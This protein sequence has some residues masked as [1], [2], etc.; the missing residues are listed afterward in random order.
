MIKKLLALWH[1]YRETEKQNEEIKKIDI[2]VNGLMKI[3]FNEKSTF[4]SIQIKEKFLKKFNQEIIKRNL[5]AQIE[6]ADCE[7]YLNKIN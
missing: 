3:T 4:Q 6:V 7:N 5:D 1:E 2:A